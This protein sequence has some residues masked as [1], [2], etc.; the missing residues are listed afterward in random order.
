[1]G[2]PR[3]RNGSA[4]RKL[5]ARLRHV[6]SHCPHCGVLLDWEHPYLDNSAELDEIWPISKTPPELRA[7]AAVD[8]SNVQV[9]CRR[10]NKLKGNKTPQ[11]LR[12]VSQQAA[13]QQAAPI[14][15]SREW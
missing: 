8:P 2:D 9:L 13:P 10:C 4:R 11:Q 14:K 3:Y 12:L 15:T 7:R 5:R 1:M 6:V